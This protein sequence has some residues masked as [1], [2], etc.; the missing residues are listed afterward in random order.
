MF[1]RRPFTCSLITSLCL[2]ACAVNAPKSELNV[3]AIGASCPVPASLSSTVSAQLRPISDAE[4][5]A[6]ATG[7]ANAGKLCTGQVFEAQTDSA[8]TL[9]RAWNSSNPNSRLGQWWAFT[10]PSGKIADFRKEYGVCYQWSPLDKLSQCKLKPGSKLVIGA[11]QSV[12]CSE[13]LNYPASPTIQVFIENATEA[14][15][16]CQD[17]SAEF[18]WK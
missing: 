15:S 4:L 11:G 6:K 16:D 7:T 2:T 8:I 13:Y 12:T 18:N 5:L 10:P 1:P 14:V 3:N 17:F 9:F